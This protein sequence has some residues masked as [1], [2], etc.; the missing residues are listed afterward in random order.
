M[1][2]G[3]AEEAM[4]FYCETIPESRVLDVTRYAAGEDGPEGTVKLA[5]ASI[6]GTEL[7]F[8]NSPVHH[9]FTFTPSVSLLVDCSS[10]E[11]LGR[12]VEALAK[13]GAFL[14]PTG[15]Y[16]FSRRFAWL[17]DRFGVSWQINLP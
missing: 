13:D 6:G 5:R 15:S 2:E 1:F 16:G 12:I 7:T 8:F 4:T 17:N 10:E 9:A 14:M 3:R 11:E